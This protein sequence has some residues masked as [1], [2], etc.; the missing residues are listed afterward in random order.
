MRHMLHG[1][2]TLGLA[3]AGLVAGG[4]AGAPVPTELID[5]RHTY[6]Q[7]ENGPAGRLVPAQVHVAK[8]A[9]DQAER[10]FADGEPADRTAG[11]AY[12]AERRA[13]LAEA[14]AR[15]MLAQ[16]D[17]ESSR[18][19]VGEMIDRQQKQLA[20][21]LRRTNE[22]LSDSQQQLASK[23]QQLTAQ[24]QQLASQQQ[25]LEGEK[26]ARADAERQMH[27]AI[28]S[29]KEVASV[30]EEARG[31]V[32][33]LSGAVL[34]VTGQS[35]LL[36]I[37]RNK[38]DQVAE[39]LKDQPNQTITVE[40]HTDSVGTAAANQTLSEKRAQ[41]V[42]EYLVSR[43]VPADAIKA[44]GYGPTRPVADNKTAEGRADNRRVEI[45]VTPAPATSAKEQQ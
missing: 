36:P 4:C 38:L 2:V 12:V 23:Q 43:G 9:L 42:R 6:A 22:Q 25:Q 17:Q 7:V 10:S 33:S 30:K 20:G 35:T 28:Q 31:M 8:V 34:F 21:E 3:L 1:T 13:Q 14:Q 27:D 45:V 11:L 19:Q 24:Q 44:V 26:A 37:A 39:V 29:L 40:G 16:Q 41:A 32:I 18:R 5:A 15:M